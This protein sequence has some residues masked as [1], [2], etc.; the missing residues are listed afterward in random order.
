MSTRPL[1]GS[2]YALFFNRIRWVESVVSDSVTK[3]SQVEL[4]S[5]RVAR[6]WFEEAAASFI[7][8]A[9]VYGKAFGDEHYKTVDAR[10]KA[11]LARSIMAS[12]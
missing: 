7:S 3:A 9:A 4:K 8:A 5:G 6:P 10:D 11:T 12:K 2:T 1:F